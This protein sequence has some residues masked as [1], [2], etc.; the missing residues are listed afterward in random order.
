MF[1][2]ERERD[3]GQ[4]RNEIEPAAQRDCAARAA[5]WD[6]NLLPCLC[7]LNSIPYNK[8]IEQVIQIEDL[9]FDL[10]ILHVIVS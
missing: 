6:G 3:C 1:E 2:V 9:T 4:S 8:K 7:K 5:Q 10:H